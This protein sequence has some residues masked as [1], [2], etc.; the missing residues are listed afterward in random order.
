R[1]ITEFDAATITTIHGFAAQVRGALGVSPDVDG[2][3]RLVDDT[4]D[5]IAETCADALIG[6]AVRDIPSEDLPSLTDLRSICER[7]V[8]RPDVRLVPTAGDDDVTPAQRLLRDLVVWSVD[9]VAERRRRRGTVSFDDLLTQLRSALEGPTSAAVV[10]AVRSRF[11]VALIDEFQDTD[12]VQW[13]IF[14]ALFGQSDEGTTLVL[15][16]DPKQAIYGFRGADIHTYLEAISEGSGTQRRSLVTNWRSDGAVLT[17]LG[18]L[19][20]RATFGDEG[21]P[22]VPVE[23]AEPNRH[24]RLHDL[25][26]RPLPALSLRLAVGGRIERYA[27]SPRVQTGPAAVAVNDDLVIAV[28]R[29]FDGARIPV[30]GEGSEPRPVRPS[31]IA[32]L[33]GTRAQ[34]EDVQAALLAQ[35]VPAVLASGDSVLESPAAEQMRYLLHAMDR[36]SDARRVR[37]FALSW[38]VGWRAEQVASASEPQLDALQDQL[39]TWSDM[40]AAHTAAEVLA[41]VWTESG[42]V[43]RVLRAPD[44]DRRLTDLE[45]LAELFH[46]ATP[47]GLTSVARMLAF[48]DAEPETEADADMEGSLTARRVESEDEAVQVMTIWMAKGQEFPIV[49]LPSLWRPPRGG[50]PVTYVD[51]DSGARTVDLTGAQSWPDKASAQLR[52]DWAAEEAMGEQL[53]LLYVALTRAQHQAIVWW[54]NSYN[55]EKTALARVLFARVDGVIDPD[56]YGRRTASIPADADAVTS[57][58]A[59]VRRAGDTIEVGAVDAPATAT[60]ERWVDRNR[61]TEPLPLQFAPFETT[62]D[63]SAHRWSFSTI[64]Q[65]TSA[66]S[67]DPYDDSQSDAGAHDEPDDRGE[68]DDQATEG[69]GAGR[70]VAGSAEPHP[71]GRI[72]PLAWLPAGTS[73]GTLVH[74]VLEDVDFAATDLEASLAAGIDRQLARRAFDL[75]P[76]AGASGSDS[77]TATDSG[78]AATGR[79][80]LVDGLRAALNSPLGPLCGGLALVDVAPAHRLNEMSFELRLAQA[81]RSAHL[82]EVGAMMVDHLDDGDPLR[83]WATD[84]A[85]GVIDVDLSGHLTGSIDLIMRMPSGR[86]D[87]RFVVADY[88]TNQLTPWGHLPGP[89]DYHPGRLAHAMAQHDY[90]LQAVLYSVALHRYLRWRLPDYAPDR[91]LGGVAYLFLRG[92]TGPLVEVSSGRPHGVFGWAVPPA[93]VVGLSDLLD[94]QLALGAQR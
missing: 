63:R 51:R 72:G 29:L 36:P 60:P 34:G 61:G 80:L 19:F 89:G 65:H 76:P 67:S 57:L 31:D 47:G 23:P 78:T 18:A 4:R 10:D 35:G 22:F 83:P 41:R 27:R 88:K 75:A 9:E 7:V 94:G 16:G 62:L 46:G 87:D 79:A 90:P 8:G 92:M 21:I 30:A 69:L 17:S 5:L 11:K 58:G 74:A 86:G 20:E 66:D 85:G 64:T 32:V 15:V 77:G 48:L 13:G 14:S 55:S 26:G 42:V 40:L 2:D 3:A 43:P 39:R 45:H 82:Q 59:L 50:P 70:E 52:A 37:T 6:A 73:F 44:G 84:L 49:C 71:P 12:S 28:R 38:F 53:R 54:A 33:V 56:R 24:R 81:G 91:H 25:G 1:A 93:L 68:A